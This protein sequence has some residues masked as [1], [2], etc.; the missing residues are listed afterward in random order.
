MYL[1]YHLTE[2]Y[3]IVFFQSQRQQIKGSCLYA[4]RLEFDAPVTNSNPAW[5][6]PPTSGRRGDG[7][8]VP[9]SEG[10]PLGSNPPGLSYPSL[11]LRMAKTT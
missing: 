8:S 6:P 11:L 7:F 2:L 3:K 4:V 1:I 5:P 9:L 10:K